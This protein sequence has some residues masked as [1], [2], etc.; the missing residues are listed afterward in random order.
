M[1][2]APSI[3]EFNK[4]II[5]LKNHGN[6]SMEQNRNTITIIASQET[7]TII[8]V[9]QMSWVTLRASCPP[10]MA[11]SLWYWIPVWRRP[12]PTPSPSFLTPSPHSCPFIPRGQT[13]LPATRQW[14]RTPGLTSA[15]GESPTQ[16]RPQPAPPHRQLLAAG[17]PRRTRFSSWE[18]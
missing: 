1:R 9:P 15:R 18:P 16:P 17:K 14:Q 8:L 7:W 11:F 13:P 12:I 3:Q 10:P 2:N 5:T 6:Y 4:Y